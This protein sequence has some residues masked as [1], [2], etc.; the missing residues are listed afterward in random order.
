MLA[1]FKNVASLLGLGG[2]DASGNDL[3]AYRLVRPLGQGGM[4]E[5]W[6]AVHRLLQ[7]PAAIKIVRPE[8]LAE[9]EQREEWL[10]RFER[11]ARATALLE[12]PHTV[13]LYEYGQAGSGTFY[14][15]MELLEGIDLESFVER[16]GPMRPARAVLVL[17]QAAASLA[18][19][20]AAGLVHRDVK[21]GNLFLS[22]L[23]LEHDFVKVLDFGLVKGGDEQRDVRIT[24]ADMVVGTPGYMAPEAVSGKVE[25]DARA[26][27]YALGCVAY[28]LLTGTHVFGGADRTPL[29]VMLDHAHR[30]PQPP[31]LRTEAPIPPA[32]E[33]LVMR[34]LEKDRERRPRDGADLLACLRQVARQL[35]AAWTEAD[36]H[37]WWRRHLPE[38]AAPHPRQASTVARRPIAAA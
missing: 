33:A 18:E 31:S 13:R 16:F 1:L 34:C 17:A 19:A 15:A 35:P 11:E 7:R 27:V 32:L 12:S 9:A 26:D 6:L 5:V 25:L 2:R 24:A 20:H 29:Q 37:R 8:M 22:R 28:W 38:L 30:E 14:Y 21:P 3:G 36:A 10:R 4:G 23:G